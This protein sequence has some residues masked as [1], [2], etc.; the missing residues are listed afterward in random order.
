MCFG[1]LAA[2]TRRGRSG[3]G[4]DWSGV[5]WY[6][7]VWCGVSCVGWVDGWAGGTEF[8]LHS[9]KVGGFALRTPSSS[10]HW[11]PMAELSC[12]L[13]SFQI[14]NIYYMLHT[15]EVSSIVAIM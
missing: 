12:E 8:F 14:Y 4:V 10:W 5:A 7:V 1:R 9:L 2:T 6:D 13:V 15:K 3:V 11:A